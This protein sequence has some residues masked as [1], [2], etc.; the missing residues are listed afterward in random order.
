V[1]YPAQFVY[2]TPEVLRRARLRLSVESAFARG[3][4]ARG[5][6]GKKLCLGHPDAVAW[7]ILGAISAEHP[8]PMEAVWRVCTELT[9]AGFN[10]VTLAFWADRATHAE[11]LAKLDEI[12]QKVEATP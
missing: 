3:A 8:K 1:T 9:D 4:T 5:A 2:I 10:P 7:D 11:V 6:D 12:I